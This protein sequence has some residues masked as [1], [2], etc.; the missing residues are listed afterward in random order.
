MNK[1]LALICILST[2]SSAQIALSSPLQQ[3]QVLSSNL[4][5]ISSHI[6]RI[7]LQD[8]T[9]PQTQTQIQPLKGTVEQVELIAPA[10][11][12]AF[13]RDEK[14][15]DDNSYQNEFEIMFNTTANRIYYTKATKNGDKVS[16]LILFLFLNNL[17]VTGY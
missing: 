17:L 13:F 6:E 15:F 3:I 9:V 16:I 11:V 14:G 4:Q 7:Y 10:V 5:N 2:L 12:Q 1:F 8:Q